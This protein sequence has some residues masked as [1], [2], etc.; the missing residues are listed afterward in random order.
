VGLFQWAATAFLWSQWL[1]Q[2]LANIYVYFPR[3]IDLSLILLGGLILV[4]LNGLIFYQKGGPI[5]KIVTTKT[6]VMT[7]I[8][9]MVVRDPNAS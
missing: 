2:D 1:I 5:Q 6:G 8:R 7:E 4:A 9:L 3:S